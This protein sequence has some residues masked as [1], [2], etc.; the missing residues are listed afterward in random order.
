VRR[1]LRLWLAPHPS[2]D[3]LPDP[4]PTDTEG[5]FSV[6]ARLHLWRQL[7]TAGEDEVQSILEEMVDVAGEA[8]PR[9]RRATR[10][11]YLRFMQ[12]S[13]LVHLATGDDLRERRAHL[14]AARG[15]FE[16]V[17]QA[18]GR[19]GPRALLSPTV[20]PPDD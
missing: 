19:A 8:G 13:D 5:R 11:A 7:V 20:A 4:L 18:L 17:Y 15:H 3:P 16:A 9:V 2:F 1:V 14:V 10:K 6:L 12:G